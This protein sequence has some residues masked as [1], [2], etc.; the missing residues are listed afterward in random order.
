M[1]SLG[2]FFGWP[3]FGPMRWSVAFELIKGTVF[4]LLGAVVLYFGPTYLSFSRAQ[5]LSLGICLLLYGLYKY[6]KGY[7]LV[8]PWHH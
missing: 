7:R 5:R 2:F 4:C 1:P 8:R 3:I 6:W